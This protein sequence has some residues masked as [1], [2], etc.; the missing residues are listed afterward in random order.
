[1]VVTFTDYC[2]YLFEYNLVT[3]P[4]PASILNASMPASVTVF[5]SAPAWNSHDGSGS[6]QVTSGGGSLHG[7]LFCRIPEYPFHLL[8]GSFDVL[9]HD[10]VPVILL[11]SLT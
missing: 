5:A 3:V 7:V 2:H 10:V 11:D 4:V 6:R 1:M 8:G 9:K